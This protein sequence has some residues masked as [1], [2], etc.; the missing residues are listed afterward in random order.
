MEIV[1]TLDL[2]QYFARQTAKAAAAAENQHWPVWFNG[3]L[4]A[5][6]LPAGGGRRHNFSVE[7]SLGHAS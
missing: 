1:P 3:P 2:M 7:F 5:N 4:I 6:R